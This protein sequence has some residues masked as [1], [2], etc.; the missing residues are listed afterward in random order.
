[1]FRPVLWILTLAWL[2]LSASALDVMSG[3]TKEELQILPVWCRFKIGGNEQIDLTQ[4]RMWESHLGAQNWGHFHHFCSSLNTSIRVERGLITGKTESLYWLNEAIRGMKGTIEN[5]LS[6]DIPI[7]AQLY[8][9]LGR[10]ML[11]QVK[12]SKRGTAAEAIDSLQKAISF[13]PKFVPP[14]LIMADVYVNAGK[15]DEATKILSQGLKIK[16]SDGSLRR[17]MTELGGKLPEVLSE[18]PTQPAAPD[19]NEPKDGQLG[20]RP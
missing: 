12:L 15:K 13:E 5:E 10:A 8:T 20:E 9:Y 1:M 6:R 4:K 7:R 2:P 3:P 14:Y 18:P 16:P 17:R 19:Q 11:L